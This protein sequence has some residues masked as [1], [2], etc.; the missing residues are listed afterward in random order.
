MP[1][2]FLKTLTLI[3]SMWNRANSPRACGGLSSHVK[4]CWAA[5][6]SCT[7]ASGGIVSFRQDDRRSEPRP[8]CFGTRSLDLSILPLVPLGLKNKRIRKRVG[9]KV[10]YA[11]VRMHVYRCAH[12]CACL[13]VRARA[14]GVITALESTLSGVF[15]R[16]AV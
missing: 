2:H 3:S 8:C 15:G 16:F 7:A 1:A 5:H 4:K 10:V 13:C 12:V 14:C 9:G 6:D 11:S